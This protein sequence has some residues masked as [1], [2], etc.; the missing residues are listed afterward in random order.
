VKGFRAA[1]AYLARATMVDAVRRQA[2]ATEVE[3]RFYERAAARAEDARFD[4]CSTTGSKQSERMKT[5]SRN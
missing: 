2:S 5:G 4:N 1:H 3:T